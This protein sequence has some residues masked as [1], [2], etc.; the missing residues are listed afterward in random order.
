MTTPIMPEPIRLWIA[1]LRSGEYQQSTGNLE[2]NEGFCCLGVGCKTAQKNG[3][4][5]YAYEDKLESKG[6]IIGFSLRKQ[7][8]ALKWLNLQNP[9]G[10]FRGSSFKSCDTL[11]D[12]NDEE[13]YSFNE[14]ADFIEARWQDLV[15]EP[16]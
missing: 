7:K 14:I 11:I 6:K 3:I 12:L 13:N 5:I 1:D 4:K 8:S 10:E 16:V 15:K 2:N 9:F